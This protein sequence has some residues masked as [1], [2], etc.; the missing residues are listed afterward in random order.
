M[1][2]E[3]LFDTLCLE[4]IFSLRFPWEALSDLDIFAGPS[5]EKIQNL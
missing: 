2:N 5:A 4:N 3:P 1:V